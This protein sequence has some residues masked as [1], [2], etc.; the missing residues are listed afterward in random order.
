MLVRTGC[1]DK[2]GSIYLIAAKDFSK[3][4]DEDYKKLLIHFCKKGSTIIRSRDFKKHYLKTISHYEDLNQ[5]YKIIK[6]KIE[7]DCE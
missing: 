4:D 2:P 7:K 3:I 5:T 1:S 6:R